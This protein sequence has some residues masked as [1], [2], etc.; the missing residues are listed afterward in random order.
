MVRMYSVALD[1]ANSEVRLQATICCES[2][3]RLF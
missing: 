1:H 3:Q 2:P